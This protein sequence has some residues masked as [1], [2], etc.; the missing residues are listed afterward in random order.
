MLV[1]GRFDVARPTRL[2]WRGSANQQ[3]LLR[4]PLARRRYA[5]LAG[6][7]PDKAPM[8]VGVDADGIWLIG[9]PRAGDLPRLERALRQ[10]GIFVGPVSW[11]GTPAGA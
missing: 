8:Q 1:T 10:R 5:S 3:M 9:V 11:R 7:Q 6:H 4:T 2:I